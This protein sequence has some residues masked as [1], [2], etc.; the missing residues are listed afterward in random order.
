MT[1]ELEYYLQQSTNTKPGKYQY[2][3]DDVELD[4]TDIFHVSRNIIEHHAG[5]NTA[6]IPLHRYAE[7][8]INK[9]ENILSLLE[10]N[11]IKNINDNI[12]LEDKV[13]GNCFNI[14]KLA[15]SMLRHLGVPARMRY[16]Y[17][18]Y[19]YPNYNH[20]QVLVEYWDKDEKIWRRGDAS[21]NEEIL[22]HLGIDVDIDLLNVSTSLSMPIADVWLACRRGDMDFKE[23]GASIENKKRAGIGHIA[24]KL[25]HDLACLNNLEL[26]S[27]DFIAPPANYLRNKNLNLR[28]FDQVARMLKDSNFYRIQYQNGYIPF[29]AK[30]RRILRKSR[31][32]GVNII[33]RE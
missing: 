3:F 4:I 1:S 32:S 7:M 12:D 18:T 19:F 27:C 13:I 17:C 15:V 22:A 11:G 26:M 33:E 9:V 28:D 24:H 8:E 16:T 23:F 29:C 31:F 30:P 6:K 10:Q 21:M 5:I 20:E 14:S 2:Y 25:T